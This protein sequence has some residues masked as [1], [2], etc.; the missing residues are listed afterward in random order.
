MQNA[1][2]PDK[3]PIFVIGMG[4]S[5][6]TLLRQMLSAHP[7]IHNTHEAFFYAYAQGTP[8][9]VSASE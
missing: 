4:R 5:G 9:D 2:D 8:D 6:T 7:R 3:S 1:I